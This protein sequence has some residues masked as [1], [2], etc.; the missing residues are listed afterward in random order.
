MFSTRWH[1]PPQIACAPSH[2]KQFGR[3]H[4]REPPDYVLVNGI[5]SLTLL[6]SV[7]ARKIA[8]FGLGTPK[9]RRRSQ[10]V[11]SPRFRSVH[12]HPGERANASTTAVNSTVSN[13]YAEQ[14]MSIGDGTAPASTDWPLRPAKYRLDV[15][16]R[17]RIEIRV[18][19]SAGVIMHTCSRSANPRPAAYSS[20]TWVRAMPRPVPS[21]AR[22]PSRSQGTNCPRSR[23]RPVRSPA[24][25]GL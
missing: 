22:V 3:K 11:D 9:G 13:I 15:R 25:A 10:S 20:P 14:G 16:T 6:W 24:S 12:R 19:H 1:R 4:S 7:S 17:R 2:R 5:A 23:P 18:P 8:V 21:P